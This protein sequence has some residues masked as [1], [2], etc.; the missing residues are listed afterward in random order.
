[1]VIDAL[2][3]GAEVKEVT[4]PEVEK[5]I[6]RMM[7]SRSQESG[8]VTSSPFR[9]Q[10]ARGYWQ[11]RKGENFGASASYNIDRSKEDG[12]N[13]GTIQKVTVTGLSV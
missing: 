7:R 10:S 9:V 2:R 12:G 4:D 5:T 11:A 3:R 6:K 8:S 13:L 1:M